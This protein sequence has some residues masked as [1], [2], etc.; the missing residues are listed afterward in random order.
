MAGRE[1][2]AAMR[3]LDRQIV[4]RDGELAG[5]VDD[6]EFEWPQGGRR[7]F[8]VAILSGPAALGPRLGSLGK[9]GA[10]IRRRLNS[11]R[12]GQLS[13]VSFGVVTKISNHI[14]VSLSRDQ[15]DESLGD[16]WVKDRIISK[17]PGAGH[18]A[19]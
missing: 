17:I 13:R 10:S 6:L 4:D 19:E 8:V 12:S 5:K 11:S 1:F 15:L 7:P 9:W 2:G 18:E 3:L 14:E 16:E